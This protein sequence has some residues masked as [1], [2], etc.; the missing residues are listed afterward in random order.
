MLFI[1][2]LIK[3]AL[4]SLL[5]SWFWYSFCIRFSFFL[6]SRSSYIICA[7]SLYVS[8]HLCLTIF[9]ISVST[10]LFFANSSIICIF[11]FVIFY[12]I[13]KSR[14]SLKKIAYALGYVRRETEN[15]CYKINK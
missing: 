4:S 5:L 9:D 7:K 1:I 12:I 6:V 10:V 2:I 3:K 8:F 11:V 15:K 14:S 13:I